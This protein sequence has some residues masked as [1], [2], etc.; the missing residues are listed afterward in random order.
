MEYL[1]LLV[2]DANDGLHLVARYDNS[3]PGWQFE[4]DDRFYVAD[5]DGNGRDDLFV[6]NGTNWAIPYVGMLRSNGTSFTVVRRYDA[7]MPGW[8]MRPTDQHHVGDFDGDGRQS[9][10]VFNGDDWSIPYLGV[11]RSDGTSLSM[12]RRFDDTLPG[13]QMRPGDRH[14]VGDFDGDGRDVVF[15]FNGED[16][17]ISYLGMFR[18]LD[19]WLYLARRYDGNVPGWQMRRHDTHFVGDAT[20]DGRADLFVYNHQ[21]WGPEYLGAMVSTGV[22]LNASWREDWVGEWNLGS[23]DQFEVCDYEGSGAR[24]NLF[25]HNKDWFGIM[26][27]TPS[28]SLTRIYHQWIHNYR[29]GRNW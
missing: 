12:A 2:D 11:F 18:S 6:F 13:W 17:S 7:N 15:V 25:V 3:M 29:H 14:Y 9:L 19:N 8:Q 23:V 4:R 24:R 27:A 21:D 26:R 22:G 16:W 20:G 28:I 1:G 5:F 10:C